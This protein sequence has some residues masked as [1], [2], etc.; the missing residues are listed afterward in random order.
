MNLNS[1]LLKLGQW[2]LEELLRHYQKQL[3][4]EA[5]GVLGNLRC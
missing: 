4:E 2:R 1:S 3:T 5:I